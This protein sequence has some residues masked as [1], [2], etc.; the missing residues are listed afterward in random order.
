ML[1][2]LRS[3]I[4]VGRFPLDA[5]LGKPPGGG[6]GGAF[7]FCPDN[8]C[9]VPQNNTNCPAN[10]LA[11]IVCPFKNVGNTYACM[12][13]TAYLHQKAD[14]IIIPLRVKKS[15]NW[16]TNVACS[17][18]SDQRCPTTC[19][20]CR[21]AEPLPPRTPLDNKKHGFYPPVVAPPRTPLKACSPRPPTPPQITQFP[22]VSEWIP[23]W[24]R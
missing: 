10:M 12:L 16:H 20:P 18:S 4:P 17:F 6:G 19:A 11:L 23:E 8:G 2:P 3:K 21:S 24:M 13:F 14:W 1:K 22:E 15:E 9:L 7:A 5:P